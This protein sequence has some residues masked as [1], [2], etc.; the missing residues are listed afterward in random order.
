MA[1]ESK[2]Q[3]TPMTLEGFWK[4]LDSKF[5]SLGVPGALLAVALDFA[6]KSEWKNVALTVLS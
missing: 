1:D 2:E 3:N 5:V 4:F 6:R